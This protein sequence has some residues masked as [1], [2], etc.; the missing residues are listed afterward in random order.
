MSFI[1]FMASS[2]KNKNSS[3]KVHEIPI[4][5]HYELH[6]SASEDGT[7]PESSVASASESE[8]TSA[9]TTSAVSSQVT[10]AKS[11][12]TSMTKDAKPPKKKSY[13]FW[14]FM[15][16]IAT[17]ALIF[18]ALFV[19]LNFGSYA[20]V[21]EI[22]IAK[23][24]GTYQTDPYIEKITD[25]D[26]K[27]VAQELLPTEE[28]ANQKRTLQVPRL[29]LEIAPPD[30]R[31]IISS[32]NKNIPIVKISTE[33]LIKRDWGALEQDIQDALRDGVVHY[34]GTANPGDEGNVVITGHSSYFPWDPGRFKDVFADLHYVNEGDTIVVYHNQ[35]KYEYVI[36]EILKVDPDQV[37]VL[38]QEGENRLTLIT[39][40][41]I[42]TNWRRLVVKARPV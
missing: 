22:K 33:N 18:M 7:E 27:P 23:W 37:E 34:P 6:L 42:G 14:R 40:T 2:N 11:V 3:K 10:S 28:E 19:V 25:T 13:R 29:N 35:K 30:D 38:T 9:S 4:K 15:E 26:Q 36:Y 12:K 31:I 24:L 41:P 32:V 20:E 16:W 39:C 8:S 17:S 21:L 1:Y 5:D